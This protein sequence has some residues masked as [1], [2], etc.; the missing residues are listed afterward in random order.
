MLGPRSTCGRCLM[1][2]PSFPSRLVHPSSSSSTSY[3]DIG[4]FLSPRIRT[5]ASHS[6]RLFVSSH[7][8]SEF[9]FTVEHIPGALKTWAD[10]RT[11]WAAPGSEESPARR[12]SALQVPPIT[13]DLKELP[14]LDII[15]RSQRALYSDTLGWIGYILVYCNLDFRIVSQIRC[16]KVVHAVKCLL[17]LSRVSS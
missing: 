6:T 9:N 1:R 16:L 12:L 17:I 5:K 10:L 4:S 2:I 8:I 14:P 13:A 15:F 3:T 7:Q 11:R